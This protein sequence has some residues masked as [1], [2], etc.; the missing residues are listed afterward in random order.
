MAVMLGCLSAMKS[1]DSVACNAQDSTAAGAAVVFDQV[2]HTALARHLEVRWQHRPKA[3]LL[4]RRCF[5]VVNPMCANLSDARC[6][7]PDYRMAHIHNEVDESTLGPSRN[8]S[9]GTAE[10]GGCS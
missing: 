2:L 5:L 8:V 9:G 6:P 4:H 3:M 7:T 1:I 10:D